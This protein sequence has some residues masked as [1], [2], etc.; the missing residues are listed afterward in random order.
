MCQWTQSVEAAP[1]D[2]TQVK[3]TGNNYVLFKYFHLCI[4]SVFPLILFRIEGG[5]E[6]IPAEGEITI[7]KITKT[8]CV[9]VSFIMCF[10]H[11]KQLKIKRDFSMFN[12]RMFWM[13]YQMLIAKLQDGLNV[14]V[15]TRRHGTS[16]ESRKGLFLVNFM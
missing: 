14:S 2:N 12:F 1:E 9:S 5:L 6:P 7:Y 16:L 4:Y 13:F 3:H 15:L 11:Y 8:I 10:S